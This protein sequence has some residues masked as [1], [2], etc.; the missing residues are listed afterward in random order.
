MSVTTKLL[1]SLSTYSTMIILTIEANQ[2]EKRTWVSFINLLLLCLFLYTRPLPILLVSKVKKMD[3]V[4][5]PNMHKT[6]MIKLEFVM[7][8]DKSALDSK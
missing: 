4:Y 7:G 2:S 8:P 3:K 6:K 1:V 5:G